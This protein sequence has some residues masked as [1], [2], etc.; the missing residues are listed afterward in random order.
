MPTLWQDIRYGLRILAKNPGFTAITVLTLALGIGANSGIFSV[1]RQVLLQRL[2]VP[3]PQEL[4][5]L[6]TGATERAC[7]LR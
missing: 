4:V 1:M 2:P 5:L 7:Q 6:I 3:R